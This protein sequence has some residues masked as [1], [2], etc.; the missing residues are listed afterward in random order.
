[1]NALFIGGTGV[2]S[3]ACARAAIA[4]GV[5]VT[6]FCRGK[7]TSHSPAL[8]ARVLYG[9]IRE[10]SSVRAAL[11]D[12]RFDVV[13]Q[14]VGFVP[15]HV[16]IDVGLFRK[17]TGQYIFI[18]SAS[19]YLPGAPLPIT[20][21]TP[22]DNPYSQYSRD[23]IACEARLSQ[24]HR[25]GDFP[26]TI[27]RPSH[28]YDATSLPLRGGWTAVDRMR[29]GLPVIVADDGASLWTLT[30]SDDFA[31]AFVALFGRP[32]AFGED[33]HVTSD[34]AITWT[35]IH[36]IIARAAGAAPRL[37][38][39]PAKVIAEVDPDWGASLLGDKTHS[40]VFDNSKIK[41]LAKG[42][43]A[44]IPF[45]KGAAEQIAWHDADAA[46]RA[47]DAE[48]NATMDRVLLRAAAPETR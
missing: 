1:M 41:R 23:K 3:S 2:I 29:R 4:R 37:A 33:F 9:D 44:A 24:A 16:E 18:S 28:T 36:E 30:H 31:R 26:V 35:Q 13:V 17:R 22:L 5:D 38:Y 34:E 42:Y 11:G 47:V 10:P 15:A 19:A 40:K 12:R 8:G 6:L 43:K 48:L 7:T 46:R 39:V 21:A 27:V 32:E 25:D 45:A 20:E 14:W